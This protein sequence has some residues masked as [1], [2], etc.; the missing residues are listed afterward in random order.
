LP[1]EVRRSP[2][3]MRRWPGSSSRGGPFEISLGWRNGR[4]WAR[5]TQQANQ[6]LNQKKF[7]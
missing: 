3:R 7:I 4:A 2:G 1:D 6:N 5:H